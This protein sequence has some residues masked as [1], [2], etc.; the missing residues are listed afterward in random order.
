MSLSLRHLILVL[1]LPAL[2]ACGDSTT[3]T[4]KT[5]E[6]PPTVAAA[7]DPAP[8]EAP[9]G[10]SATPSLVLDASGSTLAWTALKNGDASVK[11][12]FTKISGGLSLTAADLSATTGSLIVDLSGVDSALEL[13][14]QRISEVFFGVAPDAAQQAT[15]TLSKLSVDTAALNAGESTGGTADLTMAFAGGSTTAQLPVTVTRSDANTWSFETGE[16]AA[17]S[18]EALGLSVPLAALIKLC[19]HKSVG[20]SVGISANL[21]FQ[22]AK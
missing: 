18:I 3:T 2:V 10:E 12:N 17:V 13:R 11:G 20:D 14:D 4:P 1:A 8:Q 22:A 16:G 5:A 15:V 19:A 6:A 7:A 21:T 9:A